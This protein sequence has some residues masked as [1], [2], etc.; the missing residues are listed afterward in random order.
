M[1][2]IEL[3]YPWNKELTSGK[4]ILA[5]G[6]FDGV[7]L[8]HQ[9][10]I[11]DAKKI[12][13][14]R[15]LPLMVM[16]FPRHPQELLSNDKKFEYLTTLTE[17]KIEMTKLGVDYLV[18]INFT[19]EFSQLSPQ[20]FVDQVLLKLKANTVVAGFDYTYGPNKKVDNVN[21]LPEFAQHQFDVKVEPKQTYEGMKISSTHIRQAI[22]KGDFS[23]AN[24][25]LGRPYTMSGEIVHGYRRGHQLGFPTA[26]L[27]INHDK[28][29]PKEGVYATRVKIDGRWYEAMTNVGHNDTF[30]NQELTIEANIFDF[31][32]EVYGKQMTIEWYKFMRG[33]IKFS[34]LDALVNQMKQ[35]QKNIK[36]Y[37]AQNKY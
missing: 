9:K 27:A 37:F 32:E 16:T 35:D 11:K 30:N 6:F 20:K 26:N 34:G 2:V 23:L 33:E 3:E 31:D 12:A 36:A 10:L 5:L 24:K 21:N 28:V 25:L 15:N 18:L 13:N 8:G 1:K 7:H 19:K 22:K 17:K 4:V 14:K 29:L